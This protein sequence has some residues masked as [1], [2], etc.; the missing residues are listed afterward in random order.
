MVLILM[1]IISLP[2]VIVLVLGMLPTGVAWL[3]DQT[4]ER[5]ATF[6]VGGIN[7]CGVFP[8]VV[9]LWAVNHTIDAALKMIS[10]VFVLAVMYAAAG[11]G[12]LVY[13]SIPPVISAFLSVIA[14]RRVASLRSL[15]RDIVGEW[16]NSVAGLDGD[17][18]LS[19]LESPDP[20]GI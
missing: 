19:D 2:T 13:L 11:F 18:I 5:F 12:W 1:V 8:Y 6:C 17:E 9:K 3:I 10:D 15:Q 7:M 20:D 14:Q 16:G 4:E